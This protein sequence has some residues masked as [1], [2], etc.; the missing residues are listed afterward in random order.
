MFSEIAYE[1]ENSL[2]SNSSISG[3]ISLRPFYP[4]FSQA[5]TH[6]IRNA[7]VK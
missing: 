2:C 4:L 6:K 3:A 5:R 7:C 1:L